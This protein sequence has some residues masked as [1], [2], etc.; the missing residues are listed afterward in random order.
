M[1]VICLLVR[2]LS[3]L[4]ELSDSQSTS[5]LSSHNILISSHQ[6]VLAEETDFLLFA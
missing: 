5:K 6:V 3:E 2:L 4:A 1:W